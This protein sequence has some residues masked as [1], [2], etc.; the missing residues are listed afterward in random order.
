MQA[1]ALTSTRYFYSLNLI[2]HPIVYNEG[3]AFLY[4]RDSQPF[5][6]GDTLD[7]TSAIP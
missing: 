6:N 7:K 2:S 5:L 4:V 3:L 1:H